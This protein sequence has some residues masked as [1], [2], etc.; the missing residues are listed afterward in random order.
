V[1]SSFLFLVG[2]ARIYFI[3]FLTNVP[4]YAASKFGMFSFAQS[5]GC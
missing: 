2:I 4:E 1:H 3:F 5:S